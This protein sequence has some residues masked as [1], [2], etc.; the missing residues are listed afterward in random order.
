MCHHPGQNRRDLAGLTRADCPGRHQA[1]PNRLRSWMEEM[2]KQRL[3]VFRAGSLP[4]ETGPH[5]DTVTPPPLSLQRCHIRPR[6]ALFTKSLIVWKVLRPGYRLFDWHLSEPLEWNDMLG[7]RSLERTIRTMNNNRG[8][9]FLHPTILGFGWQGWK[10]LA[11]RLCRWCSSLSQTHK[12]RDT[13]PTFLLL[14][15]ELDARISTREGG[16]SVNQG[17]ICFPWPCQGWEGVG[18][19][20]KDLTRPL[21]A[22]SSYLC[23]SGWL[24]GMVT[25]RVWV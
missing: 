10:L 15:G 9:I 22:K 5:T 8:G 2:E 7:N 23:L 25:W 14:S 13:R 12:E 4:P 3:A 24:V 17:C 11:G 16:H 6:K 21:S 20:M 19:L 1:L 18:G